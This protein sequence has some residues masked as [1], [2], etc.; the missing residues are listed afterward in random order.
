M[1]PSSLLLALRTRGFTISLSP[2][3]KPQV[4]PFSQLT[5]EDLASLK[6][7]RSALLA[8]LEA[9]QVEPLHRW[10][11]IN[12]VRCVVFGRTIK[13]LAENIDLARR[14]P[15]A[16]DQRPETPDWRS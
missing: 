1:T 15:P 8:M 10:H 5:P 11:T 4:A 12:G 16:F 2:A 6:E 13:E 7:H 14:C 9:E 3:G